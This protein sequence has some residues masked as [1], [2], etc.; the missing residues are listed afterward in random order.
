MEQTVGVGALQIALDTLRTQ[1]ALV[2]RKTVSRLKSDHRLIF[3]QQCD[4]ALLAAK[5]TVRID[6]TIGDCTGI[7]T[8]ANCLGCMR[9]EA[10]EKVFGRTF[11]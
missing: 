1:F 3:Y 5:A 9:P 10:L 8:C 11:W 4:A 2:E 6:G 7:E